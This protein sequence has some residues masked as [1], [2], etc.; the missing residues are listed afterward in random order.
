MKSRKL[1]F[2]PELETIIKKCESCT[3]SMTDLQGKPYAVPMNFGYQDGVLYLHAAP[4]G[5][6]IEILKKQP[7]VCVSFSTDHELRWQHSEVACSYSMRYRSVLLFGNVSFIAD[8]E[9]KQV[10]LDVI[11]RHYTDQTYKYSLPALE[12]VCVMQVVA[13]Q[14]EGRAYGY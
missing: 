7:S 2:L 6:K 3:L 1:D 9:Q 14:M 12:N 11:M 4:D 10:A 8:V 5:K 13:D